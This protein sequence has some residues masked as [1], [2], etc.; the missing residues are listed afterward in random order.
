METSKARRGLPPKK[1]FVKTLQPVTVGGNK[2]CPVRDVLHQL[3]DKWSMLVVMELGRESTLRFNELKG[4]ITGISQKMLTVTMK[5]LE[6]NGLVHRKVYPQIPPKVE[7]TITPL[8]LEFLHH[9]NVLLEW[10]C[11]NSKKIV[12]TREKAIQE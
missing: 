5:K 11:S 2:H 12:R 9:L 6:T 4:R 7:Y 10:A 3:T 8:G 1:I